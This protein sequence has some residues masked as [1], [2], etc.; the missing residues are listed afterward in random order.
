MERPDDFRGMAQRARRLAGMA[1]QP[2]VTEIL[3]RAAQDFDEIAEDIEAGA[4]E[5]RHRELMLQTRS[6]RSR[7]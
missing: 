7:R 6:V 1:H 3:R 4:V 2:K 5:I